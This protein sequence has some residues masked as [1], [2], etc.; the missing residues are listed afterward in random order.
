MQLNEL[1][2]YPNSITNVEYSSQKCQNLSYCWQFHL[3][4]PHK[5]QSN[6]DRLSKEPKLMP[7][8]LPPSN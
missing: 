7:D 3:R 1:Q 4:P 5:Y 2:N 6:P 8:L